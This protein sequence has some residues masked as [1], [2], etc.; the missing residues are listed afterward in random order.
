MT[1]TALHWV[2]EALSSL[3]CSFHT[4]GFLIPIIPLCQLSCC[5]LFFLVLLSLFGGRKLITK[6]DSSSS[7]RDC[8]CLSALRNTLPAYRLSEDQGQWWEEIVRVC[9]IPQMTSWTMV[10][11]L[12]SILLMN[13]WTP[14]TRAPDNQ[15]HLLLLDYLHFQTK[16]ITIYWHFLK[17]SWQV[18]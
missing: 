11:A 3:W 9:S 4:K 16:F 12:N 18:H 2:K 14:Q 13:L 15:N 7:E 1:G 17:I 5:Y 10:S 8:R 6:C